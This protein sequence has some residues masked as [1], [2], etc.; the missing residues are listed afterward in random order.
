LEEAVEGAR[1]ISVD[2]AFHCRAAREIAEKF[3]DADKVV[4]KLASEIGLEI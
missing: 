3:F 2:Y 1:K 4:S